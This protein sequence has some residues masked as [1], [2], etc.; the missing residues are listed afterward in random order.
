MLNA[1]GP[2]ARPLRILFSMRNY[3][4]VRHFES[5]ISELA[6]RGHNLHLLAE[7]PTNEQAPDWH[8]AAAALAASTPGVTFES[9]P[10]ADEDDWYDLRLMLRLGL[11]YARFMRPEY[12]T[13]GQL[14][15]RAR[16]RT[17]SGLRRAIESPIGRTPLGRAAPNASRQQEF[18]LA[19]CLFKDGGRAG[20]GNH[21]EFAHWAQAAKM[22]AK[23]PRRRGAANVEVI[24]G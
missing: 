16:V 4:Y 22:S 5:V 9:A 24:R 3:W 2:G 6:S 19:S 12:R 20:F 11:D 18:T 14:V 8:E 15:G 7:R 21:L 10:R 17:P 1:E 23:R 13:L